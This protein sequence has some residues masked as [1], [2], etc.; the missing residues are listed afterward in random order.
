MA[1]W[2]KHERYKTQHAMGNGRRP[3]DS[4]LISVTMTTE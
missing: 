1:V 4:S 2:G 3:G